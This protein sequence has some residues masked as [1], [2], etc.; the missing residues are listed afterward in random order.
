MAR[1]ASGPNNRIT[2]GYIGAG[3]Q[4]HHLL[5]SYLPHPDVQV[6]AVCDVD[7]T[8]REHYRKMVEE[9]YGAKQDK[10]FRG[11][12][13]LTD[14]RRLNDR[15]DID[16]VVVSTPGPLACRTGDRRGQRRQG[17]L[18]RETVVADHRRGP[19][20]GERGSAQQPGAP[21]RLDAAVR[22]RLLQRLHPGPQRVIGDVKKVYVSVGGPSKWC[23]LP[24]EPMEP[25]S[26][27]ESLAG[28]GPGAPLPLDPEPAR[29]P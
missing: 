11:C 26:G 22:Q 17:H 2:F 14:F 21:D 3:K 15:K 8:R 13:A 18:L 25:G 28:P 27:L 19:S 1:G 9:F 4:A 16:A 7:T 29:C 5:R 6:V 23:D 20:D 12:D 24:E 10:D